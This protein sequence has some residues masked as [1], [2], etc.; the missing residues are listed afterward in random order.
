M[1]FTPEGTAARAGAYPAFSLCLLTCY[2]PLAHMG[3]QS[4]GEGNGLDPKVTMKMSLCVLIM[5]GCHTKRLS[6]GWLVSL[7]WKLGIQGQRVGMFS[8]QWNLFP[9]VTDSSCFLALSLY[10]RKRYNFVSLLYIQLS[11]THLGPSLMKRPLPT[12]RISS[13]GNCIG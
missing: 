4:H 13:K 7:F 2:K 1:M 12:L 10:N 11:P 9:W 8:F 6:S 5:S 3:M